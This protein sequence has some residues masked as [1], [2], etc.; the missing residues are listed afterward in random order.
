GAGTSVK[1]ATD[2]SITGKVAQF[3]RGVM[4]DVSAKLLAQ[5]VENLERDVL[6]GAIVDLVEEEVPVVAATNPSGAGSGAGTPGA[7]ANDPALAGPPA[8]NG[9][10]NHAA[11]GETTTVRTINSPEATPVDLLE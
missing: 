4:A 11:S 2:L 8:T 9:S 1:V 3:G 6:S 7:D 5:F 10:G